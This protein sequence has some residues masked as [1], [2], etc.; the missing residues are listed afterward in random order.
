[1]G[2]E[3]AL[4]DRVLERDMCVLTADCVYGYLLHPV[5]ERKEVSQGK[6]TNLSSSTLYS[7]NVT[8]VMMSN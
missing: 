8:A 3:T 1:V 6:S 4:A 2:A 7:V 5:E